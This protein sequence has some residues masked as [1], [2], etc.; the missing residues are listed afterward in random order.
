MRCLRLLLVSVV[1]L[2]A[3]LAAASFS[4]AADGPTYLILRGRTHGSGAAMHKLE[5]R[6]Y[7]YG[8]FGAPPRYHFKS[9]HYGY[10]GNYVQWSYR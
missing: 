10:Y 4:H 9:K 5:P 6:P 7:A 8:W 2:A 3:L 1:L